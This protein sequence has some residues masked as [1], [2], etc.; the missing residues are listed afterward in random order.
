MT[1]YSDAYMIQQGACNP[2]GVARALVKACDEAA[3]DTQSTDGVR[4]DPAVRLI[5]HQLNFLCNVGEFDR[6]MDT[7][8]AAYDL[9]EQKHVEN[10]GTAY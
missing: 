6:D 2:R 10:G 3:E 5:L 8:R 7:W 9:C 4:G 1:R